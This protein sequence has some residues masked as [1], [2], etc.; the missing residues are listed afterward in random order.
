M[1]LPANIRVNVTALFP[2]RAQGANFIAVSKANGVYTIKA[3]YPALADLLVISD[4]TTAKVAIY[5]TNT[6]QYNLITVA[7][8]MASAYAPYR[9]VTAAGAVT[10]LTTDLTILLNKTVGA[11]TNIILP[12]SNS[13]GG[14]SVTVKDYKG[15]ANT[16]NITFVPNG[17]ETIDGL[18]PAAAITAGI[19]LIDTNFGKRTLYPLASGGWYS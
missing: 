7:Q 6:L 10:I 12:A 16:N 1:T 19:A 14:A 11:A 5:D 9:L 18:S 15:D 8:F 17:T 13:R 4:P 2:S 3:N